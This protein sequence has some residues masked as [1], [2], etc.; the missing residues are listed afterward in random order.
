MLVCLFLL[1][2]PTEH[3]EYISDMK[4]SPTK[5][6]AGAVRG[7][8]DAH[9]LTG[10]EARGRPSARTFLRSMSSLHC[11]AGRKWGTVEASNYGDVK[12]KFSVS[13]RTGPDMSP[14]QPERENTTDGTEI[15][16]DR[17]KISRQTVNTEQEILLSAEIRL[18]RQRYTSMV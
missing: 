1:A 5:Q 10:N 9:W 7:G 14:L 17:A 18:A 16:M 2:A 4:Q 11:M 15:S 8:N 6:S 13:Y 3:G 12:Y